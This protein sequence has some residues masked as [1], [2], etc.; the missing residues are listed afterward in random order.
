[1]AWYNAAWPYRVKVTVDKDKV[2]ADITA[3]D[4]LITEDN[5]PAG[6]WANVETDGADIVVTEA[7]GVTKLARDLIAIDTGAETLQIR[8]PIDVLAATDVDVYLYYGNSGASETERQPAAYHSSILGFWTLDESP[9]GAGSTTDRT[10]NYDATPTGVAQNVN[11]VVGPCLEWDGSAADD[12]NLGDIDVQED[13]T[14]QMWV[15]LDTRDNADNQGWKALLWKS[16]P[17]HS[18]PYFMYALSLDGDNEKCGIRLSDGGVGSFESVW[19]VDNLPLATWTM[20]TGTYDGVTMRIYFNNSEQDNGTPFSGS[21]G[22]NDTDTYLGRPIHA[23]YHRWDGRF[24]ET[25]ILDRAISA[26]EVETRYNNENDPSTFYAAGAQERNPEVALAGTIDGQAGA[27]AALALAAKLAGTIAVQSAVDGALIAGAVVSLA[28]TIAAR[29]GAE[30]YLGGGTFAQAGTVR[31]VAPN[32][33]HE[34]RHVPFDWIRK[35]QPYTEALQVVSDAG[36]PNAILWT[37]NQRWLE[38][39]VDGGA[40]QAVGVT[41]A[42]AVSL[43]PLAAG[44]PLDITLRLTV[45]ATADVRTATAGLHLGG[46]L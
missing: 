1:M 41:R 11:G 4:V 28:G 15:Y 8:A 12:V 36:H 10:G 33:K 35:T 2:E 46:G 45:P 3:L 30:A 38:V 39:S 17:T 29:A 34:I 14:V 13:I 40:Y 9:A 32:G 20:V 26:E 44:V 43:G 31:L 27:D 16:P 18:D 37:D 42:Q 7:D 6:F 24:D 21:L 23:T 19:S 22:Q 25:R 5:L